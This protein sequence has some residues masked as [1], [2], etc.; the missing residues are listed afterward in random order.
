MS[1]DWTRL[2]DYALVV[3]GSNWAIARYRIGAVLRYKLWNRDKCLGTFRS[4]KEAKEAAENVSNDNQ[5]TT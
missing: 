5:A 2:G 4:A 3:R 1:L